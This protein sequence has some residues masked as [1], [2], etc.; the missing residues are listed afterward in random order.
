[1]GSEMCIR[2]RA[3]LAINSQ[4]Y[5]AGVNNWTWTDEHAN[6]TFKVDC[7][8]GA[9]TLSG[10]PEYT[11]LKY[12]GVNLQLAIERNSELQKAIHSLVPDVYQESVE[13]A[14]VS[15]F[16]RH[17]KHVYPDSWENLKHRASRITT[18]VGETPRIIRH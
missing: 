14:R 18:R 7:T 3:D 11:F 13:F 2:D 4:L 16:L 6:V 1:M 8:K 5:F 9:L 17:V 12:D 10:E 15:A